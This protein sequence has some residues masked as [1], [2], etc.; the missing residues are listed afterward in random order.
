M[1]TL[2]ILALTTAI[3]AFTLIACAPDPTDAVPPVAAAGIQVKKTMQ[4][5]KSEEELKQYLQA[6][7]EKHK[8]KA[9][10]AAEVNA[11]AATLAD[12]APAAEA[13]KNIAT[14][15]VTNVQHAG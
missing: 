13:A 2:S 7:A 15:S 3:T 10:R 4:A 14:D 8:P 5:F 1:K 6:L 11:T 9:K 12:A